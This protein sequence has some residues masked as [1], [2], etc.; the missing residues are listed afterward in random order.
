MADL[1]CPVCAAASPVPSAV[2]SGVPYWR[3]PE[4][5]AVFAGNL[6]PAIIM[7]HNDAPETRADAEAQKTR[8]RRLDQHFGKRPERVLDFGCG[9]GDYVAFLKGQGIDAVG[10]DQ[11]TE[12]QLSDFAPKSFDA[13]NMV[14]VI[15]HLPNPYDILQKLADLLTPG[16][17]IYIESSFADF[18]GNPVTS[19]Y[20][21]PAIGHCC[22]H[23]R[24]SM[25]YL[26]WKLRVDLA[27]I[28]N[29]VAV[30]R[31]ST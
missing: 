30:L 31:K 17:I 8:L 24:R 11:D 23:S 25:A 29:N 2:K 20:V 9:R 12:T 15:E 10:V 7:T 3:C 16:G 6:D 21:D 27:W 13:I 26:G 4:C 5:E 19:S 14:E 18:I 1:R 22:I 28:N